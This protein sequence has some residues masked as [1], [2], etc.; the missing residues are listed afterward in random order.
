MTPASF[1]TRPR[2]LSDP[3]V[4][5][6]PAGAPQQTAPRARLSASVPGT[7]RPL[8]PAGWETA[9]A[10]RVAVDKVPP[11]DPYLPTD[12]EEEPTQDRSPELL[13]PRLHDVKGIITVEQSK[14][15]S[16]ASRPL[17]TRNLTICSALLIFNRTTGR[18]YMAH[19]DSGARAQWKSGTG[20]RRPVSPAT[21]RR[22]L[23]GRDRFGYEDFMKV[24]GDKAVL[25]VDTERSLDRREVV[26]QIVARGAVQLQPLTLTLGPLAGYSFWHLAY[27]PGSDELLVHVQDPLMSSVRHFR[28]LMTEPQLA[29][30]PDGKHCD[31]ANSL[32]AYKARCARAALDSDAR[33]I[34]DTCLA[35]VELRH[36][37]LNLAL[38]A[39]IRLTELPGVPQGFLGTTTVSLLEKNS[40][41]VRILTDLVDKYLPPSKS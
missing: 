17:V 30:H 35:V 27:R 10:R 6:R 26:Q 39:L 29:A 19:L 9:P 24:P 4:P 8:N 25:M 28:G 15:A 23:L 20:D 12:I 14:G 5:R 32:P 33:A 11:R 16:S 40:R 31:L 13:D 22:G 18:V 36:V 37:N 21:P 34:V 41:M 2:S 3:G 1:K 38:E 7:P